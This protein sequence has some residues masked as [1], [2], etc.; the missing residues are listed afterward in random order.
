MS[1]SQGG[2][3]RAEVRSRVNDEHLQEER[4]ENERHTISD[5]IRR[6]TAESTPPDMATVT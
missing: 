5:N 1:M 3:G 2:M 4:G 6:T